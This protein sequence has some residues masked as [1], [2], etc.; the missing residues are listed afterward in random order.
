MTLLLYPQ[1]KKFLASLRKE[2]T[3]KQYLRSLKEH[4]QETYQHSIRVGL[5]CLDIGLELGLT[6]G[7]LR[8]LGYAGLLHDIG[9]R[10]IPKRILTKASSLNSQ[11]KEVMRA[12]PRLG[13]LE[14]DDVE[15]ELVRAIVV[16]HHEFKV[17]SYPRQG[18][19]RRTGRRNREDRRSPSDLITKMGGIVAVADIFDALGSRRA[20]KSPMLKV[21]IKEFLRKQFTG[22]QRL[23]NLILKRYDVQN[24][25]RVGHA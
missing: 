10:R 7:E 2:N 14:L 23:V 3:I 22:N 5:L 11:E 19:E 17:D 16:T 9:K 12:H 20:Y 6:T 18:K 15:Y 13:F 1:S 25:S 24:E 4:H 8:L 21:E